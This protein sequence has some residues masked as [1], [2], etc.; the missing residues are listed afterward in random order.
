M[1]PA[2][3]QELPLSPLLSWRKDSWTFWAEYAEEDG[4]CPSPLTDSRNNTYIL[5]PTEQA[6]GQ[7]HRPLSQREE[8]LGTTPPLAGAGHPCCF[9]SIQ[10]FWPDTHRSQVLNAP[11][12]YAACLA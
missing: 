11:Q 7:N 12:G 6:Q 8:A 3:L 1:C 9:N 4:A 2:L 5:V 10:V